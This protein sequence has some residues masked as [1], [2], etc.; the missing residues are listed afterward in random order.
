MN[1]KVPPEDIVIASVLGAVG[2]GIVWVTAFLWTEQ[3]RAAKVPQPVDLRTSARMAA[4]L[5]AKV[6]APAPKP[7]AAPL[8]RSLT[9]EEIPVGRPIS[10][11]TSWAAAYSRV[12]VVSKRLAVSPARTVAELEL[13]DADGRARAVQLL[14]D[15]LN[16]RVQG[17]EWQV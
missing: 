17:V 9:F 14:V 2:V 10:F 8:L 13:R 11:R 6:K 5:E 12:V 4:E 3:S 1:T 15:P 16:R 7:V